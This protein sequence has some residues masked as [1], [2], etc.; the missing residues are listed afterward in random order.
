MPEPARSHDP[1][2]MN[3]FLPDPR[4]RAALLASLLL[5]LAFATAALAKTPP[6]ESA[7]IE[8][9]I[10]AVEAHPDAV[11]IRNGSDHDATEAADHLRLKWKSAGNRI[12]TARDFIRYCATQSSMTG[13]KYR[14]RFADGREVDSADFFLAELKRIEGQRLPVEPA[15]TR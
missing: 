15:P 4:R 9:L 10:A 2:A 1:A 5:A 12:H 7:K 11:F 3:R 6:A 14:I 13:R 8:A